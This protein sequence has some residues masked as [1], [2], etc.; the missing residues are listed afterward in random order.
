MPDCRRRHCGLCGPPILYALMPLLAKR[1][2]KK[3]RAS[4]RAPDIFL[5]ATSQLL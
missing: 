3:G 4:K 5:P 1:K 2:K